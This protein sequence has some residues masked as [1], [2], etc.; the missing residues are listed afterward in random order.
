MPFPTL[1]HDPIGDASSLPDVSPHGDAEEPQPV[2]DHAEEMTT[3]ADTS[4]AAAP[5]EWGMR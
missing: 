5:Y 4:L 2:E 3:S 1:V